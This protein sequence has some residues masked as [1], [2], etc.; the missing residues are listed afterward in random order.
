MNLSPDLLNAQF[1]SGKICA[2]NILKRKKS[3]LSLLSSFSMSSSITILVSL[4]KNKIED[5][6]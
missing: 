6:Y 3:L 1:V 4:N 2:L 5:T